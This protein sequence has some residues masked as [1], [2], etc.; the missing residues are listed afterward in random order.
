MPK[1]KPTHVIVHRIELQEKERELLEPFVKAK[2]VEQVAKSVA[3]VG[4]AGA[5][6]VGAWIAWWTFD[7][8]FGWMGNARDKIDEVQQTI[9]EVDEAEG[10][11][12]EGMIKN[13]SPLTRFVMTY[14]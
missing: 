3:M 10:T 13:S 4:V 7:T 5:V 11:N 12:Y 9:K 2:E 6:G 8:V 14:L 1:A